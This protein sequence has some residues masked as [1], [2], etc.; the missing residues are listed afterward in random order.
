MASVHSQSRT[1][2]CSR[3]SGELWPRE[4]ASHEQ[5]LAWAT[6]VAMTCV[7]SMESVCGVRA[8]REHGERR[9]DDVGVRI[10]LRVRVQQCDA[11][12]L[13]AMVNK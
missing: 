4:T 13:I 5:P 2:V 8:R 3:A 12:L 7:C 6:C 11:A 1:G 9:G 10:V